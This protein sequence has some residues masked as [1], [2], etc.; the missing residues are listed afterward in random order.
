M[1]CHPRRGEGLFYNAFTAV[2]LKNHQSRL[3]CRDDPFVS[4]VKPRWDRELAKNEVMNVRTNNSMPEK[5]D[6]VNQHP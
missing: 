5:E 2:S 1:F 6:F 4:F 3:H